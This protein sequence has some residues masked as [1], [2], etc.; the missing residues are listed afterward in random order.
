MPRRTP[1]AAHGIQTQ[2]H[3]RNAG[4]QLQ[5]TRACPGCG[6]ELAEVVGMGLGQAPL[7]L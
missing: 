7:P 6:A 5:A 1:C 2:V 4:I 3:L